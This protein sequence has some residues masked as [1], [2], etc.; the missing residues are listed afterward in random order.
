MA[1]RKGSGIMSRKLHR[2]K[3]GKHDNA[4]KHHVPMCRMRPQELHFHEEQEERDGPSG[5][6]E[7][8]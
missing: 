3:S 7:I 8:L 6:Q 1:R 5:A 2:T 4:G